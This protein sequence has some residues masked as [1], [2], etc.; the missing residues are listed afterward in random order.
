MFELT[1]NALPVSWQSKLS[2]EFNS[3]YMAELN[4]FLQREY[5]ANKTIF[6][7]S[8]LIF[9]AF[10][11]TEFEQT[12]VVIIGQDPYHGPRQ[13]MGLSFSVPAGVKVPPSLKNIFKE[14]QLDLG[15]APSASGDLT[16]WAQQGVLLL[17]ATLTVEQAKAGSHQGKG[18]ERFTDAVIAALNTHRQGLVFV[19]WGAFAQKK[20]AAIDTQRHLVL[21]SAHP[22]PLSAHR[23]FFG[24]QLFSNINRYLIS[25]DQ[26]PIDWSLSQPDKHS[27]NQPSL[28]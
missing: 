13:A 16:E 24:N 5:A 21:Q 28:F 7:P 4:A 22:S 11:H 8:D 12:R 19:L 27:Q 26:Q 3:P 14:R 10:Q 9:N 18:W 2:E 17:N 25:L 15:L 6:P 23:G 1:S 20:G